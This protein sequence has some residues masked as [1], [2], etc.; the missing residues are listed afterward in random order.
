MFG[1]ITSVLTNKTYECFTSMFVSMFISDIIIERG[2]T[3][4]NLTKLSFNHKAQSHCYNPH[5]PHIL[6]QIKNGNMA[7]VVAKHIMCA[8]CI[9][10][11]GVVENPDITIYFAFW[12]CQI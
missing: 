12:F 7:S 8:Y 1:K 4:K 6:I 9:Y 11:S 2:D 5:A 10:N 3:L